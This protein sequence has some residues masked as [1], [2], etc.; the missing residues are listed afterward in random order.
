M[1]VENK[2]VVVL[3][4]N[5][6]QALQ[7]KEIIKDAD[8]NTDV[9]VTENTNEVCRVIQRKAVSLFVADLETGKTDEDKTPI[10]RMVS[11]LRTQEMFLLVPLILLHRTD[12]YRIQAYY[13]WNCMG[14]YKK[15]LCGTEFSKKVKQI[16]E[17]VLPD[18]NDN[19]FV[20]KRHNVRYPVKVG[21][22]MYVRYFERAL[23]LYMNDGNVLLVEQRPVRMILELANAR[24]LMQCG[25]GVLINMMY[26]DR[27]NFRTKE[28]LIKNGEKLKIGE[29]Y[30]KQIKDAWRG[31]D[32]LIKK[33]EKEMKV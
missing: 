9:F 6:E 7:I 22:L 27:V 1:N 29:T 28:I 23:H 33:N 8:E 30:E 3:T 15:P 31:I 16:L 18:E 21:E 25:R 17:A 11:Q 24:C 26:V 12:E 13:E 2:L 5:K 20:I 4:D 32:E 19:A 14:Y 10:G